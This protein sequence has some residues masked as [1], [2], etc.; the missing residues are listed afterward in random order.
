MEKTEKLEE[1]LIHKSLIDRP[2]SN[3]SDNFEL[4]KVSVFIHI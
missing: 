4:V 1:F 3:L 2:I